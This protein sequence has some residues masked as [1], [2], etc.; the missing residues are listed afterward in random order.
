MANRITADDNRSLASAFADCSASIAHYLSC[1][2]AAI[3]KRPARICSCGPH[4]R[5]K[6][7]EQVLG[8]KVMLN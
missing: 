6:T 8:R 5:A 2:A 4:F 3:I 7:A 1:R